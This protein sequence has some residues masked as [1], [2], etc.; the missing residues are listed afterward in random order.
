MN[1]LKIV[2]YTE[3][4]TYASFFSNF[5]INPENG[6]KYTAKIFT[7]L[8]SFRENT[9]NQKQHIL[10]TDAD[11]NS[12]DVKVF[13]QIIKISDTNNQSES[14]NLVLFKY[15]PLKDLMSQVIAHYYMQS[16]KAVRIVDGKQRESVITFYSASGGTGKT[17]FSLCLAKHLAL[18]EKKVF[19]LNL[20]LLHTTYLYFKEEK[21][22]SAEVLYYLKNN[23]ERLVPKIESLKSRDALSNIDYF[24]L[25]TNPEEMEIITRN[26]VETFIQALKQTKNYDY[27][28]IDLDSSLHVRNSTSL[29]ISDEIFWI[30]ST[31]ETSFERTKNMLDKDLHNINLDHSK[32]HF[33]L[34]KVGSGNFDGFNTYNFSIEEKIAFRD[35]WLLA[36]EEEKFRGDTQLGAKLADLLKHSNLEAEGSEVG[37]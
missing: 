36:S 26:E 9:R 28:I 12:E 7:N 19:Y 13:E 25:P 33:I 5:M 1:K 3:D 29:D 31:D 14:G 6:N 4:E 21:P 35:A 30:L 18:L 16:G 2:L 34:N 8:D 32:V 22:S 24:A 15:Q 11:V 37:S 23:P 17:L 27:I 10:L 20:E